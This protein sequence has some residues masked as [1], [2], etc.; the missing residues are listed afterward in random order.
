MCFERK[1]K[2]FLLFYDRIW[3]RSEIFMYDN[4]FEL[5]CNS[6]SFVKDYL[7]VWNVK[8]SK[9]VNSYKLR[10]EKIERIVVFLI[11]VVFKVL[12]EI[13]IFIVE[14]FFEF[15]YL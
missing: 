12:F 4:V 3:F 15:C 5:F 9:S 1:L 2:F 7:Y 8:V 14:C 6:L 11:I 10:L 13:F